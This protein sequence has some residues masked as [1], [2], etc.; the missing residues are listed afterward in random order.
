MS[1]SKQSGQTAVEYILLLTVAVTI[2][3][4]IVSQM[5]SRSDGDEGFLIKAWQQML[6]TMGEDYAD[7]VSEDPPAEAP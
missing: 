6:T 4:I 2:A 5:V 1:Q 7:V 3:F